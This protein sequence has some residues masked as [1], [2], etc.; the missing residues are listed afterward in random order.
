MAPSAATHSIVHAPP[1]PT[2]PELI[3]CYR[4]VRDLAGADLLTFASLTRP[5]VE[6]LFES[7]R[8]L[9]AEFR[10]ERAH[11]QGTERPSR[12]PPPARPER[13]ASPSAGAEGERRVGAWPL[14][15]KT[16]VLLFEK[17]SLRTKMSFE[18]GIGLLGGRALFMDHSQQKLG[19]REAVKDYAK[20][21]ERWVDCIIARVFS[22]E[23]LYELAEHAR[24]PVI[25]ALSDRFHP[26]Q[27]LADLFTVAEQAE[28]LGVPLRDM[29]IAYVGDGNNVCH[30][31][32]HAATML[33]VSITVVSPKGY[34]PAEDVVAECERFG[35][36]SGAKLVITPDV[37]LVKSHH[38]VYTDVWVSMGQAD[39]AAKRRKIFAAYQVN[40][41][42]MALAS[43]GLNLPNG[44]MF[45]HCL[46]AQ[47]GVEVTDEV[48]DSVASLVYEQA[49]NRMH[50]QDALLGAM[51]GSVQR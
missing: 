18:T 27:A 46:P 4:S 5:V 47:R 45:M 51:L 40:A 7:A 10:R 9:K 33:G 36:E 23:V 24:V 35:R 17:P 21:L 29:K 28:A 50:A 13:R 1:A 39:T 37:S 30:S 34:A 16:A 43:K 25:N 14:A 11:L 42:V 49:E 2:P 12:T 15:G 32:M 20:N 3:G 26:C 48:I 6:A 44:A 38:A 22:Q 31:L 8:Q 19:E 41:E